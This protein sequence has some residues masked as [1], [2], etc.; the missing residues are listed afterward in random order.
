MYLKKYIRVVPGGFLIALGTLIGSIIT[1]WAC[2]HW[3]FSPYTRPNAPGNPPHSVTGIRK[4]EPAE[5]LVG[6]Q[7]RRTCGVRIT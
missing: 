1:I 6:K 7:A 3:I 4:L 5:P 2:N